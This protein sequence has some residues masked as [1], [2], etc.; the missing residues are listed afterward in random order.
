MTGGQRAKGIPTLAAAALTLALV[1]AAC[2]SPS[3]GALTT[4]PGPGATSSLVPAQ[5]GSPE[6]SDA[7]ESVEP[8]ADLVSPLRGLVLHVDHA[9]LGKV[10]GF[11]LLTVDGAQVDFKM[12]TQ[13]NAAEFPAAHLSE[14]MAGAD[15]ILVYFLQSGSDLVVYRLED[16]PP[17]SGSP[18]S[19][20][21][22][23]STPSDTPIG[24]PVPADHSDAP[25]AY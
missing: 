9:G 8:S 1:I 12:G 5:E 24:S 18:A 16:A 21:P 11:R 23:S 4:T 7:G 14:H 25:A 22:G 13:E 20:P 6:P 19:V 2:S 3:S 17:A 10:T 15:P